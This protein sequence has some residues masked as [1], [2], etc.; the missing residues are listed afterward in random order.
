MEECLTIFGGSSAEIGLLMQECRED[1]ECEKCV[2]GE[3]TE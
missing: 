1:G 2:D 3:R